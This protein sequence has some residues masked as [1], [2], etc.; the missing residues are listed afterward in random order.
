MMNKFRKLQVFCLKN[1][2]H[3]ANN[4]K[5]FT[6]VELLL[7]VS[8]IAV[9]AGASITSFTNYTRS[10]IYTQGIAEFMDSLSVARS[11]AIAQIKPAGC[12]SGQLEGYDVRVTVGGGNYTQNVRCG[13]NAIQ[14]SAKKLPDGVVF[15]GGSSANVLFSVS[16][17]TVGTPGAFIISGFGQTKTVAVNQTGKITIQNGNSSTAAQPTSTPA[18]TAIAGGGCTTQIATYRYYAGYGCVYV[19]P[20]YGTYCD[21]TCG[22]QVSTTAPTPT[23]T[24]TQ[25]TP[26]PTNAPTAPTPTPTSLPSTSVN[27]SLSI[28]PNPAST[29]QGITFTATVT[30]TGCTPSGYVNFY[31]DNQSSRFVA[32]TT[33]S[34]NPAT[35]SYANYPAYA[36]GAGTHPVYAEY[37]PTGTC[38]GKNSSVINLIVS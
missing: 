17:G 5:G 34:G 9:V 14:T 19:P 22:G 20:G 4:L 26:T 29:T 15:L 16:N 30:G 33:S 3:Y 7:S 10:Q 21:A 18:P 1:H 12:G 8:I 28:A 32:A 24:T 27:I 11:R 36:I 13:G 25:P 37:V 23:P 2:R 6:F 31:R 35:A 38:P